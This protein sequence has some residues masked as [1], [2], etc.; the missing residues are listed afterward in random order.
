MTFRGTRYGGP[1]EFEVDECD[2]EVVLGDIC[3]DFETAMAI[4]HALCRIAVGK[5]GRDCWT[6]PADY[7]GSSTFETVY[8]GDWIVRNH[9]G[10]WKPFREVDGRKFRVGKCY[11]NLEDAKMFCR[12]N[13][14]EAFL[15]EDRGQATSPEARASW[16]KA[17]GLNVKEGTAP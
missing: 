15:R 7:C 8:H 9:Q 13:M 6:L 2:G 4:G 16:A 12:K 10:W 1:E 5:P 11:R 14:A 17:A 3:V